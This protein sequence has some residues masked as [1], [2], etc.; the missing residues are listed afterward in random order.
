[1][2]ESPVCFPFSETAPRTT[3]SAKFQSAQFASLSLQRSTLPSIIVA[4]GNRGRL[5]VFMAKGGA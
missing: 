1:M 5:W 3:L 2:A 4:Q